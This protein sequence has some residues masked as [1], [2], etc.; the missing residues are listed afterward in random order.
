M[1]YDGHMLPIPQHIK[2]VDAALRAAGY[3]SYLVGGCVRDIII[4]RQPKDWDLTTNATPEQIQEVF[5]DSFYENEYGTV[6]VV[7]DET[8]DPALK[9]V[10]ITPYRLESTYTDHRRPDE[11]RFGTSLLED[12]KRR[13]FTMNAIA[14][15]LY[16]GQFI[17][18]YKG[19]EDILS[20]T[21][22]C[23]GDASDRFSEDA[24]RILRAIRFTAETGFACNTETFDAIVSLKFQLKHISKE[25][26][27]DE[28]LKI[29]ASKEPMLALGLIQR[30]DI[31]G[32]IAPVLR[33]TV[34]VEQNKQAHKY[35][36]WEHLLRS[37]QH[38]AD[39]G[40]SNEVRM[41]ALFHDVSKPHTKREIHNG[42]GEIVDCTFYGHEVIGARV[43]RETLLDLRFSKDFV[44]KVEKLVRWH[45]F[46]SDTEQITLSA[47]RRLVRNVG[48]ENIWEL[49]DLRTCDRIG[50][51]R[52]IENP[53]R[54]RKF[55]AMVEEALRDPITVG[56]LAVDGG[57]IMRECAILPGPRIGWTLHALLA[58]VLENPSLNTAE[59]L[60]KRAKT[61]L[62]LG[63]EELKA[64]GELGMD[65]RS[66]EDDRLIK[67]IKGKH[68]VQ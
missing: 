30:L 5:P 47:V 28:F 67:E 34:G 15:D 50:S 38:A 57:D 49:L 14:Y 33:E 68:K 13:D 18:P 9:V 55:R 19:H 61:L 12:L 65:R 21:I 23:V 64:R 59:E 25:R 41:A 63:D 17:D 66:D 56:M 54:L 20:K 45:M 3:D 27:R 26:I 60:T 58:D 51:G 43:T 31:L 8:S 40:Y 48:K 52:P 22:R 35:P 10:E 24:L 39:K 16:K 46:L 37:L 42:K 4:G 7:S 6:G 53:Y 32:F 29:V 62:K 2:N 44:E 11:V 1:R 36:V